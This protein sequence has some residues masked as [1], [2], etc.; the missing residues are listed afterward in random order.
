[1]DLQTL[2]FLFVGATFALYIVLLSGQEPPQ[3]RSFMLLV[4]VFIL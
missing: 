4:V 2:T 3:L 1:M